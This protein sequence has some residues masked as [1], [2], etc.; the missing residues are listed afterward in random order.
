MCMYQNFNE[1]LAL[2]T[3]QIIIKLG[4]TLD[5]EIKDNGGSNSSEITNCFETIMGGWG[6]YS[7][8]KEQMIREDL[9]NM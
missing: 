8:G 6:C 3:N 4:D 7:P 2:E 9:I 1:L 5:T